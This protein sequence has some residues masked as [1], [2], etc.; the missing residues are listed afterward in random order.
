M[1]QDL[2]IFLHARLDEE[3]DLARCGDGDGCGTWIARGHTVDFCQSE[4][5]GFHPTIALHVALHDPARVLREVE[6]KR[7]VLARHVLSPATGDQE[8]PWDNRDDCQYD[9]ETWPCDDLLDLASPYADHPDYPR[10]L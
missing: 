5:S 1:S 6:A 4:L 2:V 9:G 8:L 7:R 10:R 3:A